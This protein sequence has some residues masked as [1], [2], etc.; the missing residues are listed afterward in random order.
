MH[1]SCEITTHD[2][3]CVYNEVGEVKALSQAKVQ[4]FYLITFI[5]FHQYLVQFGLD[6]G[7]RVHI[8]ELD[9]HQD[10]C[11]RKATPVDKTSVISF[12]M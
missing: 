8:C 11:E 9:I 2:K 5:I 12:V 6:L 7:I 3:L 10:V 1:K 4:I